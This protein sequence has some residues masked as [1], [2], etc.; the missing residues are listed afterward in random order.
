MPVG[1]PSKEWW[2]NLSS[3]KGL[4]CSYT[5]GRAISGVDWERADDNY[6]VRFDGEWHIVPPDAVIK[7]PNRA[8]FAVVWP[9]TDP[10]GKVQIRCFLAGPES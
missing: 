2:D 10:Q 1:A 6:L 9:Y 5:D 3:G 4:C 7:V 8:G